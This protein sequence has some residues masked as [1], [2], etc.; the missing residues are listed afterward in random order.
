MGVVD[1]FKGAGLFAKIAF[2]LLLVATLFAWIAY[3]C[4]G[5][6]ESNDGT[7]YGLWRWCTD[8]IYAPGCQEVDGIATDWYAAT[9]A[10]VSF[11]FFGINVATFLLILYM[12]AS[13][14]QKNGEVGMAIAIICIVTG[15]LYLIGIIVFGAKFDEDF[16]EPR[17]SNP[18]WAK[19]KLSYCFGLSIVALVFEIV[20]G[21]L[22]I[23]EAKK[24][25]GT[26]ASG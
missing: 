17:D 20:A 10:L 16:I 13:S 11:G 4:T 7:H 8:N 22:M 1:G 2:V 3:T 14:C 26:G 25:G 19:R 9:Q 23:V 24:G 6:G 18:N 21:V 15:V 12:F 5:W